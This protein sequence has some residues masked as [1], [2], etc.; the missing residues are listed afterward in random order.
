M[1]MPGANIGGRVH[2]TSGIIPVAQREDSHFRPA[3]DHTFA[4]GSL[5]VT[6][7]QSLLLKI[8]NQFV[9]Q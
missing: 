4:A 9:S 7:V 3:L 1:R 8:G 6:N 2:G 5:R